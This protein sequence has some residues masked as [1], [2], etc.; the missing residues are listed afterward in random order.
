M[1]ERATTSAKLHLDAEQ[2]KSTGFF[3]RDGVRRFFPILLLVA[4]ARRLLAHLVALSSV[5][6]SHDC[7]PA[8]R[9]AACRGAGYDLRRYRRLHRSFGLAPSS[10][11]PR[12]LPRK[13]RGVSGFWLSFRPARSAG[14]VRPDQRI[15]RCE[16]QGPLLHCYPGRNGRLSRRRALFHPR[17]ACLVS[18]TKHFSTLIPAGRPESRIRC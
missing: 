12:C 13:H 3:G 2:P 7:R 11:S 8:G 18:R 14:R 9:R 5:Q 16:G 17:R 1:R 6:Q 4:L 10:R 15:D